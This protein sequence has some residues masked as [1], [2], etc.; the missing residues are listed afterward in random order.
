VAD[1]Q[2][3]VT[4]RPRS[5]LERVLEI[6]QPTCPVPE[7]PKEGIVSAVVRSYLMEAGA[8]DMAVI[9]EID[10]DA[11]AGRVQPAV[12]EG[13]LGSAPEG[14]LL[15]TLA[16][17]K[18]LAKLSVDGLEKLCRHDVDEA[19]KRLATLPRFDAERVD[20]VL[21]ASRND[22][23][24]APGAGA[25]RVAARLGYPGS[26]YASVARALD[27]EIPEGDSS[28]VA[29]RAHHV[30]D[31]HAQRT[32]HRDVP[33]CERCGVRAS[34]SYR[35]ADADPARRLPVSEA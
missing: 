12:L 6:L 20:W 7:R 26:S 16:G 8:T 29:W 18:A 25:L 9:P 27:A 11:R 15:A 22:V 14:Q 21:L 4:R 10:S 13:L 31:G 32:C 30:L 28:D 23:S 17:L 1:L 5:K 34:C 3:K 35:G 2:S 19:K 24:V 33:A